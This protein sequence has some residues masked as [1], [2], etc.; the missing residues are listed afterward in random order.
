VPALT[1]V[2]FEA[3]KAVPTVLNMYPTKADELMYIPKSKFGTA[4]AR[5][6]IL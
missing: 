5:A 6:N 3:R 2:A 1:V 4:L